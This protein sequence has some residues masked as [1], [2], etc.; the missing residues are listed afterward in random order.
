[1]LEYREALPSED[2]RHLILSF[3]EFRTGDADGVIEH[4]VFPDGCVS[5]FYRKSAQPQASGLVFNGL[6]F[7]SLIIPV[8]PNETY[9]GMRIQPAA[10]ARL[11]GINPTGFLEN[12]IT[13]ADRAP[14][15]T[16]GIA[17]RMADCADFESGIGIFESAVRRLGIGLN[18]IDPHTALATKLIEESRGEI[19]IAE[20]A[21]QIGIS[22][23]QL[24]RRFKACCGLTPKQFQRIR[25]FRA[26]AVHLVQNAHL[27]WAERA[28]ETGFADQAHLAREFGVV[29][30]RTPTEFAE[31]VTR[32]SHGKLVSED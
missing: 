4:E 29:A 3:W 17:D 20:V 21:E 19:R 31:K 9:R 5:L 8:L 11:T 22:P 13:T 28:A 14:E 10:C 12:R 30:R 26:A 24:E 18:E 27:N 25:R 15:L 23:R 7:N 32:I 16:R 2:L 6:H 1:M